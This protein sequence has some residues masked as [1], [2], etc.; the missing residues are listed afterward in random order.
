[1]NQA[2]VSV[3][4]PCFNGESF[5]HRYFESLL[6]QT[7]ENIEVIFINDGST[8]ATEQIALSYGE[9]L[10]ARGID[11]IYICQENR[12]QAA[13]INQGLKIF[14]GNYLTWPDSDDWM[15]PDCIEKK[16]QYLE[17]NPDKG[18]VLCRSAIVRER[19]GAQIGILQRRNTKKQW[20]FEDLILESDIYFAP[21]GYM[22]RARQFLEC[23]P[24]RHIYE[25]RAGQ[26]WQ[27]LL[28]VGY[29]YACGFIKDILYFYLV[30]ENSH[31]RIEKMY[32]DR[33]QKIDHQE[34]TLNQ[35]IMSMQLPEE[36]RQYYLHMIAAKYHERR[37]FLALDFRDTE[38]AKAHF[39]WL[40]SQQDRVK[41]QTKV[42]FYFGQSG[43]LWFCLK[44]LKSALVNI[45]ECFY[46]FI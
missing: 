41:W 18:L 12:G 35:T 29:K 42:K 45:Y 4:T 32:A 36:E 40:Q 8:D 15:S 3:I 23:L 37:M 34:D 27:M 39:Q 22:V 17:T 26:N 46:R 11:F 1:M 25:G 2:K 10:R 14:S 21:G 30:R 24:N 44:T 5:V 9:K 43:I 20:I 38:T 31:S 33:V 28:P 7:Y 19:D 16:V 6:K 13:A